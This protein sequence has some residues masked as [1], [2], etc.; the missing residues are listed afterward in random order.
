[1]FVVVLYKLVHVIDH[2][3]FVYLK[4]PSQEVD[5]QREYHHYLSNQIEERNRN[6][7]LGQLEE[8]RQ[9]RE[10]SVP[11]LLLPWSD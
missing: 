8:K 7:R 5:K 3:L 10:V 2:Y 11:T 1:M 6:T 9:A 4:Y